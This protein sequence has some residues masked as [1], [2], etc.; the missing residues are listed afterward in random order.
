MKRRGETVH[1]FKLKM[2]K[3]E[4]KSA[5]FGYRFFFFEGSINIFDKRPLKRT[6]RRRLSFKQKEERFLC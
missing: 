5:F 6:R 4:K 3:E 2:K 1:L